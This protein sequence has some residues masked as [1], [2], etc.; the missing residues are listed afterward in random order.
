MFHFKTKVTVT[1]KKF[2]AFTKGTNK[3]N[4]LMDVLLRSVLRVTLRNVLL[5]KL[6][7]MLFSWHY[8]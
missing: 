8:K 7:G 4:K 1:P 6:T 5:A 2:T 3:L